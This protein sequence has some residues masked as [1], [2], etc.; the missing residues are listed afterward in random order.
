MTCTNT[1]TYIYVPHSSETRL[2]SKDNILEK[3]NQVSKHCL[4]FNNVTNE[5][6]SER[7]RS[8]SPRWRPA[9][10]SRTGVLKQQPITWKHWKFSPITTQLPSS[11]IFLLFS[12][13]LFAFTWF[14]N[15][16][17]PTSTNGFFQVIR[18]ITTV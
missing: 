13:L 16:I 1:G 3:Q 10:R 7:R 11:L 4:T 8:G 2:N 17:L 9:D 15:P 12:L 18:H 5:K 14:S 6:E